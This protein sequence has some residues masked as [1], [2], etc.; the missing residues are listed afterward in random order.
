M[1]KINISCPGVEKEQEHLCIQK[2]EQEPEVK[3]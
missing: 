2:V 3:K 1:F